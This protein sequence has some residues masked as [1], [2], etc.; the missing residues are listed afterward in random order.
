VGGLPAPQDAAQERRGEFFQGDRKGPRFRPKQGRDLPAGL[1]RTGDRR[2]IRR[3]LF[4]ARFV[5]VNHAL[6]D[7]E[8]HSR[9][10][11]GTIISARG[12]NSTV[13]MINLTALSYR[14][15]VLSRLSPSFKKVRVK[16][17]NIWNRGH[18]SQSFFTSDA[19]PV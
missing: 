4:L 17:R 19:G 10:A 9:K 18:K 2:L 1:V 15:I 13:K 11:Q 8:I 12:A 5:D 16:F 7:V 6:E 14:R 3:L